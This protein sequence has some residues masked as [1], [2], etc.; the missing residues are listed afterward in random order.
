MQAM[1]LAAGLG[2]R[3]KPFTDKHPK[4]LAPVNGKTV[5]QRNVEFLQQYGIR[6]V[7]VNVHHF[8]GQIIQ[9]VSEN[10]G[11]GS[12]IEISD[13]SS[14][15]LETGGGIKKA[16]RFFEPGKPFVVINADILTNLDLKA[17]IQAH[18]QEKPMGTL[19]VTNRHS[20][21]AL[22]FDSNNTLCGWQNEKT[23]EQ[24]GLPGNPM[25]FSGIQ[26]LDPI[27]FD[28]IRFTG[29]F[30]MIDVYLDLCKTFAFKAFD[31][32]QSLFADIGTPE[33]LLEAEKWFK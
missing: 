15:V 20:S 23:G 2:T 14:E 3:L 10:K 11:W 21:R 30:S 9:A 24:K 7:I 33:K 5:L 18:E 28:H 12:N 8:A 26:I 31:H 27:I 13:E 4:A 19:A 16:S 22:L 6:E 25:A 17:M 32:S 29:K 1:I